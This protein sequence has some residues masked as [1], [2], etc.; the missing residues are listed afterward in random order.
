[1]QKYSCYIFSLGWM[2][3]TNW[4]NG[5]PASDNSLRLE[6]PKP[7]TFQ[8]KAVCDVNAHFN[9]LN[10]MVVYVCYFLWKKKIS[11]MVF[12]LYSLMV[13]NTLLISPEISQPSSWKFVLWVE[14]KQLHFFCTARQARQTS[15][16]YLEF[17]HTHTV[18]IWVC[19]CVIE[20]GWNSPKCVRV[21]VLSCSL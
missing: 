13:S 7:I 6:I 21:N 1:M 16:N 19:V 2:W 20:T 11:Y 8:M 15:V 3:N 17:T 14:D 5:N 9:K 4:L 12:H 18:N 10:A